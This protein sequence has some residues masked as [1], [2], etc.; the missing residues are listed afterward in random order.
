MVL[1]H[2]LVLVDRNGNVLAKSP[3]NIHD[4]ISNRPSSSR[5]CSPMMDAFIV[6]AIPVTF[7]V[8]NCVEDAAAT[9]CIR[10]DKGLPGALLRLIER[11]SLDDDVDLLPLTAM[12]RITDAD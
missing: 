8:P 4:F 6:L 11:C 2:V 5:S 1:R 12:H 10:D 9:G 7:P 3:V